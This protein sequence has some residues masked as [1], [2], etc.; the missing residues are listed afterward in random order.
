LIELPR[1]ASQQV[2]C[3]ILAACD[4]GKRVAGERFDGKYIDDMEG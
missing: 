3:Q 1:Y 2:E 4:D